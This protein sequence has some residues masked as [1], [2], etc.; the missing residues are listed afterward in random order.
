[1]MNELKRNKAAKVLQAAIRRKPLSDNYNYDIELDK[2]NKKLKAQQTAAERKLQRAQS[3]GQA[4]AQ[5]NQLL[6]MQRIAQ[7][8]ELSKQLRQQGKSKDK[9][10]TQE[11]LKMLQQFEPQSNLTSQ[12]KQHN[13]V[14]LSPDKSKQLTEM[15]LQKAQQEKEQE[16][17][18]LRYLRQRKSNQNEIEEEIQRDEPAKTK[19][20]TKDL[21]KLF[22]KDFVDKKQKQQK[23]KHSTTT[24]NI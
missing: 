1:M 19:A 20:K 8:Q 23:A 6:Q 24:H 21:L 18:R 5:G 12:R 9:S 14:N 22:L 16:A 2:Y 17:Y 3:I 13:I 7:V 15:E 10:K 11:Y 4:I